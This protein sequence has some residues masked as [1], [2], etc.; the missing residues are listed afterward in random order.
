VNGSRSSCLGP[1]CGG[2]T[3]WFAVTQGSQQVYR[4]LQVG[5]M[6]VARPRPRVQVPPGNSVTWYRSTWTP[7]GSVHGTF[8]VTWHW[9]QSVTVRSAPFRVG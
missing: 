1:P 9:V 7:P 8:T 5:A 4:T 2:I 3:P 6:C